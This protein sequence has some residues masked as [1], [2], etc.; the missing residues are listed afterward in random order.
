MKI[1]GM[2]S[3]VRAG[4][5]AT[6]WVR[7]F[8]SGAAAYDIEQIYTIPLDTYSYTHNGT[9]PSTYYKYGIHVGIGGGSSRVFEFD[10][11]GEGFY[12]AYSEG[13]P[14][15][16]GNVTVSTDPFFKQFGS[17]ITYTGNVTEAG[18]SFFKR[19]GTTLVLST[20][21]TEFKLGQATGITQNGATLWPDGG[22]SAPVQQHFYGDFGLTL[23]KGNHGIENV[24][25]QL[26]YGNGIT[27]GYIVS[28]GPYGSTGGASVQLGL[29][30]EDLANP[31]TRWFTMQGQDTSKV[32]TGS[33]LPTYS[34][35][36][37]AA[38]MT[39]TLGSETHTFTD[40][41]INL[42]TGNPTPG[43][44]YNGSDAA[45]LEKFSV[46]DDHVPISLSEETH[47]ELV[48]DPSGGGAPV[49]VFS[50]LAGAAY[51]ENFVYEKLRSGGETYLNIGALLF[52]QYNV[53]FNIADGLVGLTPIPEPGTVAL[54]LLGAAGLLI[55][56]KAGWALPGRKPPPG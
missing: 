38:D 21:A 30:A 49:S 34:A 19:D 36:I 20:G 12:A 18:L 51:G 31:E 7:L 43:I 1:C 37:L 14:W 25:A 53:T 32:F 40:L 33:G 23:K 52:Q 11:G 44:D 9:T 41:G 15:W 29:S 13:A 42:D 4:V 2:M 24:F 54:L 39:L 26:T 46:V 5:L 27:A 6:A 47:L 35:E 55:A 48:S 10:T 50:L 17:N 22:G 56:R 28:L 3:G 8:L 45:T 16:G